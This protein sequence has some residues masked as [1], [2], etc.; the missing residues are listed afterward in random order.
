MA[1]LTTSVTTAIGTIAT[2][3]LSMIGTVVP[4][5]LPIVGAII[6]VGVGIKVFKKVTGK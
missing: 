6:V 3:C 4:K 5:A 2:D 1:E